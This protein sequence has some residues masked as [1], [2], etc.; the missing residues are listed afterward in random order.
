VLNANPMPSSFVPGG[1]VDVRRVHLVAVE[2]DYK[3]SIAF[4]H[5]YDLS[6][7]LLVLVAFSSI[8]WTSL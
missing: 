3:D 8:F 6:I 2:K 4:L 1:G 5:L 7:K